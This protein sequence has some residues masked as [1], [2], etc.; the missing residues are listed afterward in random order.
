MVYDFPMDSV[1][2]VLASIPLFST[3]PKK[4]LAKLAKDVHLRTFEAGSVLADQDDYGSIFTVIGDGRATVSVNGQAVGSLGPGDFFGEMALI[5]KSSRR[6]ATVTADTELH[7][8]MLTQPVFRP[9]AM[10]HPDTLW[11]LLEHLVARLRQA[12]NPTT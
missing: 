12:E 11:V 2:D 3:V 6:T 4:E 8:L 10:S 7:A 1:A 5:D 9:F